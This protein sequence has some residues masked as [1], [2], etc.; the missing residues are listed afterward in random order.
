MGIRAPVV[1][2]FR[3]TPPFFEDSLRELKAHGLQRVFGFVLAPHRSEASWERYLHEIESARERLV[4]QVSSPAMHGRASSPTPGL[5][6]P[7]IDYP[8][9]W[10]A[11]PEFIEAV[12]DCARAAWER[13]DARVSGRAELIFTAHS[14]PLSMGG[15]ARYVEQLNE[16][17]C[18]IAQHLGCKGWTLAFQSRSG[19]PREPWL[20]PDV[21]EVLRSHAGGRVVLI[22]LAFLCDHLEVLYDL[23]IEAARVAREAGVVM[24]RAETV[25]EHPKFIEMIATIAAQYLAPTAPRTPTTVMQ[26]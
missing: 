16:S 20:E 17:A 18:L 22:P 15:R 9:S 8:P 13:L 21:K 11:R 26:P 3:N 10:H 6:A 2:G 7:T 19:S 12:A 25:G 14:I 23:D 1:V 24:V 4:A 5:D